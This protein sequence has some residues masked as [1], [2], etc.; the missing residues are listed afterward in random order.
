MDESG[1]A[2]LWAELEALHGAA[3]ATV[4]RRDWPTAALELQQ[5]GL[6]DAAA[7][8][9]IRRLHAFG[10]LIGNSDMHFGNLAFWLDDTLP[11]RV[12]PAYDMLPMLWALGLQGEIAEL[13]FSP[14]P[15]LPAA[16]E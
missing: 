11:F 13:T 15:P 12:A 8:A 14:A 1:Q 4:A 7:L 2:R 9:T 10:E 3:V 6:I 5:Q 16:R